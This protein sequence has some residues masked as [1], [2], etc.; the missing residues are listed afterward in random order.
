MATPPAQC[1][2][3]LTETPSWKHATNNRGT[4]MRVIILL[5][6][7]LVLSAAT[8]LPTFAAAGDTLF[9]ENMETGVVGDRWSGVQD[10]QSL[11][12]STTAPNNGTKSGRVG[13]LA[14]FRGS[15]TNVNNTAFTSGAREYQFTLND[16]GGWTSGGWIAFIIDHDN[17]GYTPGANG[18]QMNAYSCNTNSGNYQF[19]LGGSCS[20]ATSA[21]SYNNIQTFRVLVNHSTGRALYYRANTLL[22]NISFTPGTDLKYIKISTNT[23][24]GGIWTFDEIR[25]CDTYC[26][27]APVVT[28]SCTYTS[29]N[30]VIQANHSCNIT[31]NV[32]LLGNNLTINGTGTV[33]LTGNITNWTKVTTINNAKLLI[34]S[35]G[36]L[37]R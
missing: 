36:K 25:V 27:T 1:S 28:D 15:V 33:R 10:G 37:R 11:D 8:S 23:G 6:V 12:F 17:T 22:A 20:F 14:T 19:G 16:S 13:T 30:W 34:Y 18:L 5:F 31:T 35:G 3:V 26:A 32:N 2:I 24:S 9:Y 29:G 4:A 21:R 7:A